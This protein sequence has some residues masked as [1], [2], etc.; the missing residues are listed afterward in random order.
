MEE[1]N[2]SLGSFLPFGEESGNP[3]PSLGSALEWRTTRVSPDLLEELGCG[4]IPSAAVGHMAGSA[5]WL[6]A[7]VTA[8]VCG[9]VSESPYQVSTEFTLS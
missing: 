3:E 2:T 1:G 4:Q 9:S 6:T 5:C 8:T 7:L